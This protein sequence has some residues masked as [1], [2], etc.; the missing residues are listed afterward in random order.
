MAVALDYSGPDTPRRLMVP[1]RLLA[2]ILLALCAA[3]AVTA[4]ASW[5]NRTSNPLWYAW[6]W[7]RYL[8][9]FWVSWSAVVITIYA[10]ECAV[11]H[12]LR[13]SSARSALVLLGC[14]VSLIYTFGY[15]ASL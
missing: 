8:T 15:A 2:A 7:D 10:C 5:R 14:V 3:M 13:R 12:M 4:T 9:L 1:W 6:E 11:V